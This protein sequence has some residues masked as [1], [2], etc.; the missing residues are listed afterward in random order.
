MFRGSSTQLYVPAFTQK[1][2]HYL[3][4]HRTP[5][6]GISTKDLG[7]YNNREYTTPLFTNTTST[8]EA[9][10]KATN[11]TIYHFTKRDTNTTSTISLSLEG[12][13][14]SPFT[15]G[16]TQIKEGL[17]LSGFHNHKLIFPQNRDP[18]DRIA[19]YDSSVKNKVF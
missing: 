12:Y 10:H 19:R 5:T 8:L 1:D 14:Q 13:P 9:R 16:I 17:Q 6:Q 4:P 18:I 7:Q 11:N 3:C 15:R 2:F